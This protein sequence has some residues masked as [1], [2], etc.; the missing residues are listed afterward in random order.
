MEK[1]HE[2]PP[3][4]VREIFKGLENGDGAAF[5]EHVD[6]DVD[7]TVM[8]THPLAGHYRSKVDFI[9]GTFTK[10]GQVPS[11][12]ARLHVEH[13][14][15]KDDHAVVELHSLAIA[16]NGMR[17]D[18]HYCWVVFFRREKIVRVRAY[19]DSAMVAQ[20]FYENPIA[21]STQAARG[22]PSV[23]A[24][25]PLSGEAQYAASS[26]RIIAAISITD[27]RAYDDTAMI[28]GVKITVGYRQWA[29]VAVVH[30]AGVDESRGIF[31][32]AV[33]YRR[34]RRR[35]TDCARLDVC[36]PV[37]DRAWAK[38]FQP[39]ISGIFARSSGIFESQIGHGEARDH[40]AA[41]IGCPTTDRGK[42]LQIVLDL[43]D[44]L[45]GRATMNRRLIVE[46]PAHSSC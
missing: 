9:A 12:G 39:C 29:M 10:L 28:F 44:G 33:T 42:Q 41:T 11:Q 2:C 1:A 14:I 34:V 46:I 24:L 5:F 3:E 32:N 23:P 30:E 16:K 7:W 13:L 25:K 17:F 27:G 21:D 19:L 20:L 31:G 36:L 4:Y 43:Y 6:D 8:G 26:T 37:A 40:P 38:N 45:I 18:N 22:R 35:P 15:V